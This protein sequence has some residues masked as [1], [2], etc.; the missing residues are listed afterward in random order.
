MVNK[1]DKETLRRFKSMLYFPDDSLLFAQQNM[2]AK[3]VGDPMNNE[4]SFQALQN[5]NCCRH[6]RSGLVQ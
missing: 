3:D 6:S 4:R 1:H 5:L 2:I